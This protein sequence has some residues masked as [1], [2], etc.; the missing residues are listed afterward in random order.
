RA[1]TD[2]II[3]ELAQVHAD[4]KRIRIWS[5]GCS[6]GEEAYTVAILCSESPYLRGYQIE[7]FGND[8]SKKVLA[9]AR[10]ARYPMSAFRATDKRYIDRYF[11][12]AEQGKY[13]LSD[14]IKQMVTFGH[15]NLLDAL[16]LSL[17][18]S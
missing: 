10:A 2:E 7:I 15:L 4:D 6:S 1:F 13:E 5:A 17:V 14:E 16:G 11:R 8:I 9:M 3:P 12:R 18:G